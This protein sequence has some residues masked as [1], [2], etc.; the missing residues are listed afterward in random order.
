[1]DTAINHNF[2][3]ARSES[4]TKGVGESYAREKPF[5]LDIF[6]DNLLGM[7][8]GTHNKLTAKLTQKNLALRNDFCRPKFFKQ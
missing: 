6:S 7:S 1:L 3:L 5:F 2:S 8:A 4:T